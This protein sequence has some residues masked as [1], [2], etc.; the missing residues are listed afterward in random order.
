MEISLDLQVMSKK[1]KFWW[2][3]QIRPDFICRRRTTGDR[4]ASGRALFTVDMLATKPHGFRKKRRIHD[5]KRVACLD[6]FVSVAALF[7]T[8]HPKPGSSE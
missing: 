8:V 1:L 7:D 2:E 4:M 5:L 6:G 3:V